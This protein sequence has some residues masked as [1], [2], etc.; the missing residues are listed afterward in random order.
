[1]AYNP[2]T[3][4]LAAKKRFSRRLVLMQ[5]RGSMRMRQNEFLFK[6]TAI[7]TGFWAICGKM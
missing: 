2:P 3:A 1:V 7:R 5:K 6:N 4:H